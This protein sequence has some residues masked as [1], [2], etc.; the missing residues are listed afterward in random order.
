MWT[1]GRVKCS[2]ENVVQSPTHLAAHSSVVRSLKSSY[3]YGQ[4]SPLPQARM[5]RSLMAMD[6]RIV[7]SFNV[8]PTAG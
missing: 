3:A 8:G 1:V 5:S 7:K 2:V 6:G 4:S